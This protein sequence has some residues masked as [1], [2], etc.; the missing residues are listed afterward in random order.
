MASLPLYNPLA[1]RRMIA[2][3]EN[4]CTSRW[5]GRIAAGTAT[6]L[7]ATALCGARAETTSPPIAIMELDYLDTSGEI[8]DQSATHRA[9]LERFAATLR[10]D[11]RTS[12]KYVVVALTCEPDPCSITQTDPSELLA[13]ARHAGAKF[14]LFG[15]VHKMS[16]L[17]QWAK[18]Q[19]V[20]VATDKLVF[21]RLLTFRGDDADAWRHAEGFLAK[22]LTSQTLVP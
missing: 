4:I 5:P 14:L 15:G 7:M 22:E 1:F 18:V 16:T 2:F 3:I 13:A 19:V 8:R 17:V 9:L 10:E 20:D 12:Q 21:D 6:V 11:L